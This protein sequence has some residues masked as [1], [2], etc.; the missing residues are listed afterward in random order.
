MSDLTPGRAS[1]ALITD[2]PG[3]ATRRHRMQMLYASE[4]T[5]IDRAL[6]CVADCAAHEAA[7][8]RPAFGRSSGPGAVAALASRF[9]VSQELIRK[10]RNI[11]VRIPGDLL[12]ALKPHRPGLELLDALGRLSE[13]RQRAVMARV[14]AGETLGQ[15]LR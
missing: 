7:R 4:P 12:E 15:A 13:P 3:N 11:G 9:G 8:P 2:L 10:L 1:G 6:A 5:N 14:E